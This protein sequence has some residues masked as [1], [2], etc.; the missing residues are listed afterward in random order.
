MIG[1]EIRPLKRIHVHVLTWLFFSFIYHATVLHLGKLHIRGWVGGWVGGWCY[2]GN[3][4]SYRT[5][6][7][8]ILFSHATNHYLQF[9]VA[10]MPPG[11]QNGSCL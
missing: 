2:F 5:T 6:V 1:G 10:P 9:Q 11:S 3:G 8:C 4:A 7:Y